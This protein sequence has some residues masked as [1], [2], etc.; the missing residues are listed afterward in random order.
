M[1]E[2]ARLVYLAVQGGI[3]VPIK[4]QKY[5]PHY[6]LLSSLSKNGIVGTALFQGIPTEKL[7]RLYKLGEEQLIASDKDAVQIIA[8]AIYDNLEKDTQIEL[9]DRLALLASLS[10]YREGKQALIDFEVTSFEPNGEEIQEH[11]PF[12]FEPLDSLIGGFI[13]NNLITVAGASGTGKT[14]IL[15]AI[16]DSLQIQYPEKR[17]VWVSLEM[18]SASVKHRAKHLQLKSNP[19]NVLLTGINSIDALEEYVNDNTILVLDYLDLLVQVN[20]E[21]LR[22]ALANAYAKLLHYSTRCF[23]LFNNTQINRSS[24]SITLNSL[25]ESSAKAFYSSYVL[26]VTK[27]GISLATPRYNQVEISVIKNRYGV[28]DVSTLFDFNY[29]TL[30]YTNSYSNTTIQYDAEADELLK[31]LYND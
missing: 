16:V 2:Y 14:S 17:I 31:G 9:E 19:E 3:N 21:G 13:P 8:K 1:T 10:R 11:I 30:S 26:G 7:E 20:A 24:Q 15:L 18:S 25:N 6:P 4:L 29:A 28:S 23:L 22:V 5:V 27:K 12:G